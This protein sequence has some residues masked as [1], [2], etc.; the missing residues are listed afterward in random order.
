VSRGVEVTEIHTRLLRLSLAVEESRAYWENVDPAIPADK[1]A[2][3][4]F[5]GRWFGS[6]SMARVR[7]ILAN[8]AVRFDAYPEALAV[9]RG[10]RG[11]GKATRTLICHWH[12]QLAD[13]LYRRFTGDYL[14]DR[15]VLPS[16]DIDRDR[17]ASWIRDQGEGRWAPQTTARFATALL[18]AARET[19]LVEG[20]KDPRKLSLP[21]VPDQALGYLL[22]L[23][24]G[25]DLSPVNGKSRQLLDN[26]YLRSV[27]LVDQLLDQRLRSLPGLSYHRIGKVTDLEWAA[28]DLRA[29]AASGASP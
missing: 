11:M 19:G 17:A 15:R 21:S 25:V 14:V 24:R 13:P 3:A 9:L 4:A 8:M 5:E 27:G 16:A 2:E 6:K 18:T 10:W 20:K 1:R 22:Q 29:W 26:V 28:P 12:L 7:L 23:L